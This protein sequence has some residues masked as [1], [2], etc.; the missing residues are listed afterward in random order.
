M[1]G[2]IEKYLVKIREATSRPGMETPCVTI[3]VMPDGIA[4]G[5]GH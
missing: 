4:V 3:Y 2:T 5:S 1:S